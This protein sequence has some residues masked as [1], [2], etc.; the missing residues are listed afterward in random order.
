MRF[1]LVVCLVL[2]TV[3]GCAMLD[4]FFGV[5]PDK[6]KSGSSPSDVV[7]QVV[8]PWA[9]WLGMALTSLGGIYAN[10]R[11]KRWL[12]VARS[13]VRGVDYAKEHVDSKRKLKLEDLLEALAYVQEDEG[14]GKEV[15]KLRRP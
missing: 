10:V 4:S 3:S 2:L 6:D 5:S 11:R 1:I 13:V 9:P 14:T 12:R 8:A 7:G 15:A